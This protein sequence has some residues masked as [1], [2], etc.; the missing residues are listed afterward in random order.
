MRGARKWLPGGEPALPDGFDVEQQ[1]VRSAPVADLRPDYILKPVGRRRMASKRRRAFDYS[2][3]DA[4][5]QLNLAGAEQISARSVSLPERGLREQVLTAET[6][7]CGDDAGDLVARS[8]ER[9]VGK[10][11][12]SR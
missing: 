6:V 11:R 5:T 7:L 2:E 3:R 9:R 4:R 8:E 10:E 12:R 1:L